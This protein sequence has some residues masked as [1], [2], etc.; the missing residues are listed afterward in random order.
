MLDE[1]Y[2]EMHHV[3]FLCVF[4]P[5]CYEVTKQEW[6]RTNSKHIFLNFCITNVK[7][8]P[9]HDCFE[10]SLPSS[11]VS[12]TAWMLTLDPV[13]LEHHWQSLEKQP[14][15]IIEMKNVVFARFCS[16]FPLAIFN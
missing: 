14:R 5:A 12:F 10:L 16:Y 8:N 6:G 13:I 7:G 9:E 2:S 3:F 4:D 11:M 1:D 15:T